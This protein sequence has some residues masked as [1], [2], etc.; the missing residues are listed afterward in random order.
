MAMSL[1]ASTRGLSLMPAYAKNLLP[2]SVVSRPL[3]GDVPTIAL[4]VGYSKANRS[5]ILRLFLSRLDEFDRRTAVGGLTSGRPLRSQRPIVTASRASNIRR[6]RPGR[7]RGMG[8]RWVVLAAV[9]AT[10]VQAQDGRGGAQA[11]VTASSR[12]TRFRATRRR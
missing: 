3:E 7:G 8:R 12:A 9:W 11:A 10:A 4:A 1:V 2:A 6:Q 5:P